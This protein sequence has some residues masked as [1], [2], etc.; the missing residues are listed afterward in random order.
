MSVVIGN[1]NPQ[2]DRMLKEWCMSVY[3]HG[4]CYAFAIALH[5]ELGWPIVGLMHEGT[6]RHAMVQRPKDG[7]LFDARGSVPEGKVGKPFEIS[8]PYNLAQVEERDLQAIQPVQEAS[9]QWAVQVAEKL[10]PALP[11]RDSLR[12]RMRN[13]AEELETL[14]HKHGLWIR[15]SM[16]AQPPLLVPGNGDESGYALCPLADGSTYTIGRTFD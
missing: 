9:I 16:P 6:V 3:L 13:F 15:G 7:R 11:W 10:W 1:L 4:E 5:R 2:A 12:E 8:P 14:S